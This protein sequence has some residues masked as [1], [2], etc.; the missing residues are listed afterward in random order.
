[1][2]STKNKSQF[3]FCFGMLNSLEL[4]KCYKSNPLDM[5]PNLQRLLL[6]LSVIR[7]LHM[8]CIIG[9]N[10]AVLIAQCAVIAN[11]TVK[12]DFYLLNSWFYI[13]NKQFLLI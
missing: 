5:K 10:W 11:K 1:M 4:I 8:S 6:L 13:L 9:L 2:C 12:C 7:L 3:F